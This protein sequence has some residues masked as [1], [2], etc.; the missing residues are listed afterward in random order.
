MKNKMIVFIAFG[1]LCLG[2][3]GCGKTQDESNQINE[4]STVAVSAQMQASTDATE[5]KSREEPTETNTATENKDMSKESDDYYTI[6]TNISKNE[7]EDFM[8]K[9]KNAI[10]NQDM[11]TLYPLISYPIKIK[12]VEYKEEDSLKAAK[13]KFEESYIQEVKKA[14][15]KDMFCNYQGIMLGNGE[16]WISEVLNNDGTSQ[17]LKITAFNE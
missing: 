4:S 2:I 17:G 13:I 3:T 14:S 1:A 15:T 16:V 8:E 7:V 11:D 12:E 5:T 10:V 9:V 6:A